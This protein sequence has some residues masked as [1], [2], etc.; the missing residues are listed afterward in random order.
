MLDITR[1]L[2]FFIFFLVWAREEGSIQAAPGNTNGGKSLLRS[3]YL[4]REGGRESVTPLLL[5]LVNGAFESLFGL[6]P[7]TAITGRETDPS[8][9]S[10][11]L[12]RTQGMDRL[13]CPSIV[14]QMIRRDG[15][16]AWSPRPSASATSRT[17][18][19]SRFTPIG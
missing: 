8:G 16:E 2:F 17:A 3:S 9:H 5:S 13:S 15:M 7:L 12:A 19:R 10:D 6:L 18:V 4:W 1:V 11:Y 14:R